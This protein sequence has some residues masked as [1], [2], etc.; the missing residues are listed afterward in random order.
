[1]SG[2]NDHNQVSRQFVRR[3]LYAITDPTLIPDNQLVIMVEQAIQGGAKIIQYRDKRT[4][5]PHY[6]LASALQRLCQRYAVPLIINDDVELAALVGAGV[7]LGRDDGSLTKARQ[8]LGANAIIGAT[9]H[10]RLEWALEA[11]R[12]GANYVAFGSFFPSPTKPNAMKAAISLL[13]QA[14]SLLPIPIVAIGGITPANGRQLV[15][16]GADY[17]AVIHGVFGQTDVR[18]AAHAFAKLFD[19]CG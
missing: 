2:E 11:V 8:R 7:H 18:A 17:L 6:E 1:M 13:P 14:K 3:G 19:E 15:Q 4:S 10:H 12:E 9:C 16:A 5:A